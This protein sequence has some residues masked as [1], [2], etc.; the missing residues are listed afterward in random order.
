MT[1]THT[2]L[3]CLATF[4]RYSLPSTPWERGGRSELN[5][6]STKSNRAFA[7]QENIGRWQKRMYLVHPS[8]SKF[9]NNQPRRELH[10]QVWHYSKYSFNFR[11]ENNIKAIDGYVS[12][13][14]WPMKQK[15]CPKVRSRTC[16]IKALYKRNLLRLAQVKVWYASLIAIFRAFKTI[17]CALS[18]RCNEHSLNTPQ[19]MIRNTGFVCTANGLKLFQAFH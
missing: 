5:R 4:G 16:I 6:R 9:M 10:V 17:L 13:Q 11:T 1:S 12:Y 2:V 14:N 18:R 7:S 8:R 15:S 19:T 3:G